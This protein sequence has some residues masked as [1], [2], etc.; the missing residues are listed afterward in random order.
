MK[1]NAAWVVAWEDNLAGAHTPLPEWHI[2][3]TVESRN[4][5]D[6]ELE[7]RVTQSLIALK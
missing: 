4:N 1:L 2:P 7:N 3:V 5:Y 6:A